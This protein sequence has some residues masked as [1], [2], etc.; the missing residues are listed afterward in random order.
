MTFIS[1]SSFKRLAALFSGFVI[2][3]F[4]CQVSQDEKDQETISFNSIYD[5]LAQFDSVV[6]VLKATDGHTLD[7]VFKGKVDDPKDIEQLPAP[8]WDGGIVIVSITGYDAGKPVYKT[9]TPFNGATDTKD[10]THYFLVPDG[11]LS[12]LISELVLIE[13]DSLLIPT[14]TVTPA[15]LIDKKVKVTSSNPEVIWLSST[16][17]KA[18][19][20]GTADLVFKLVSD[21]SKSLS[22][23]VAVQINSRI[24]E[25]ITLSAD[26]LIV[27]ANG[28][29]AF[30]S[31]KASPSS[32][33]NAVTWIMKD[34][35][36]ASI[37]PEGMVLG[38]KSGGTWL[39]AVSKEKPSVLDSAWIAVENPKSV[40]SVRF[41]SRSV[42]LYVGGAAESLYVVTLPALANPQVEFG[43]SDPVKIQIKDG[44]VTGLAEG[45]GWVVA[46]SKEN[47]LKNDTLNVVILPAQEIDSIRISPRTVHLFTGGTS[48]ALAGK[49]Y[50]PGSTQKVQWGSVAPSIATVDELG[51]AVSVAPGKVKIHATSAADKLKSDTIE[52]TVKH[53]PPILSI[54]QDTVVPV[55]QAVSFLPTVASQ[56]YGS[57]T[58]FKYDLNGDNVWDD[59]STAIKQLTFKYDSE[60]EYRIRFYVRDTEKN[61]TIA[62]KW[63]KAVKGPVVLIRSPLANS[64]F[65][66]NTIDVSWSVNGTDQDSLKKET[67]THEGANV[68]VRGVKDAAG[69][70]FSTFITVYYDT[71]APNRPMVHG[72]AATI[73]TTPSWT[74]TTGGLGGAGVYRVAL[75]LEN[76]TNSVEIKD[77][78]FVAATDL[79]E[80]SHTLF[81]QERDAAGNWSLSGRL[82]IRIDLTAP[83]KPEIKVTT[84]SV[85]NT[86]RPNFTWKTGGGGNGS[87]QYRIDNGEIAASAITTTD[88]A[89]TPIEDLSA[90]LHT[91][92]VRERDT[93][94]NWSPTGSA[95]V[96]LDFSPPNSPKVNGSAVTNVAPKWT[97]MTG[98]NSGSGDY[99]WKLNDT[100]LT[101][102]ATETRDS[103]YTLGAFANGAAYS[104]YVQERD[105]AGN[106][107]A[108]GSFAIK[109]DLSGPPSPVVSVNVGNLTNNPSPKWSWKSGGSGIKT[110][111]Y[112]L[113]NTDVS[114]G[115]VTTDTSLEVHLTNGSHTLYVREKD[116]GENWGAVGSATVIVDTIAPDAP[117]VSSSTASP[118]MNTKPTWNWSSRGG[119]K[120]FYRFKANDENWSN[121][122]ILGT[123]TTYK[124]DSPFGEGVATLYVQEQD[125]AG[126]WSASGNHKV[127]ID[128]TG[129]NKPNLVTATPISPVNSLRPTWSWNSGGGGGN[130]NY[131]VKLNNSDLTTGSTAVNSP[132]KTFS[133]TSDLLEGSNTLYVQELD[134]AGN[135]SPISS[136]TVYCVKAGQVGTVVSSSISNL[137]EVVVNRSLTPFV[138]DGTNS[139][140]HLVA[141]SWKSSVTGCPLMGDLSRRLFYNSV[142]DQPNF[143]CLDEDGKTI[144]TLTFNG[145]TWSNLSP[146]YVN[147]RSWPSW[148]VD[149]YGEQTVAVFTN[150]DTT[151][152]IS[153]HILPNSW[154]AAYPDVQLPKDFYGDGRP[155]LVL[156]TVRN[157]P[158]VSL[159]SGYA[160]NEFFVLSFQSGIWRQLNPD[161]LGLFNYSTATIS[162]SP[163]GD[164]HILTSEAIG[165]ATQISV[166]KFNGTSWDRLGSNS[167]AEGTTGAIAFNS[168]GKPVV[169][170]NVSGVVN[171]FS[172]VGNS[173]VKMGT[174]G[175]I[176][177]ASISLFVTPSDV[178]YVTTG[179]GNTIVFKIGFDP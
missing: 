15:N 91:L 20:P 145:S 58:M 115:T 51:N 39:H 177:D 43:V 2:L 84:P 96:T 16:Y 29:P 22:I 65:N 110:F 59:S 100:D 105:P 47:P 44:R 172:L 68:I 173:W 34:G 126:N 151:L 131:R 156:D 165:E 63:V 120:S 81:V 139:I 13:G 103:S 21:T 104:L 164:L 23:H 56:E 71:I 152:R 86:R 69:T 62:T 50:P 137:K 35:A 75:D 28:G 7:I 143:G 121:G 97:W 136:R 111:Q 92:Y 40:E 133:P 24:P 36:I 26:S 132:A 52:I 55:G 174:A 170:V 83:G 31:V 49:V 157:I 158:Y 150:I 61:D 169:A 76:Y 54:G 160:T 112:R 95:S 122:A 72:P 176:S 53:D 87:F 146:I 175:E 159:K 149:K 101:T 82:A 67:L 128:L 147:G 8:H 45:L 74:W 27:A 3:L 32:A 42:D 17:M 80:G 11:G 141:G 46:T 130:G 116:S 166:H 18:L 102:G 153:K 179:N 98:G 107:S 48:V 140:K 129:P 171:V 124:P 89:F 66:K 57:V 117:S 73:S 135:P 4:A 168:T 142:T 90:G 119:G 14:I 144:F 155:T 10:S 6:I 114:G 109:V 5:T 33:S 37:S 60:K 161:G 70:F 88:T 167:I 113:D 77:T 9:E 41:V 94:G 118:T 106:W 138:F 38:L 1:G 99:R 163:S 125:S 30:L 123:Q 127:T 134:A 12:S 154:I 64:S 162:T 79:K 19:R 85:T 78:E 148:A 178:A 25:S 108:N 93:A